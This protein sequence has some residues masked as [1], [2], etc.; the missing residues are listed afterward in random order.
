MM[1]QTTATTATVNYATTEQ[2]MAL[3]N[4]LKTM[5]YD[6]E[7]HVC[8]KNGIEVNGIRIKKEDSCI[9]PVIYPLPDDTVERILDIYN[10]NVTP[11]I[12]HIGRFFTE[13][14]L[15]SHI[16]T[17]ICKKGINKLARTLTDYGYDDLEE[18]LF[19]VVEDSKSEFGSIRV[20]SNIIENY[21]LDIDRLWDMARRNTNEATVITP[22]F[23]VMMS[24]GLSNIEMSEEEIDFL[25]NQNPMYVVTTH[26]KCKGASSIL[27]DKVKSFVE[28]SG[29]KWLWIPLSIHEVIMVPEGS[30]P[31]D[32]I[33]EM[34]QEVN[35]TQVSAYE[36]LSDHVYS[37]NSYHSER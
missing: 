20:D 33:T 26:S 4:E 36:Q 14:Y 11:E 18:Y 22:M 21:N 19:I 23:D 2:T 30:M 24:L 8:D 15:D 35:A 28:K 37:Y 1:N 6:A 25:R 17:G 3:V 34:V 32:G 12:D 31:E 7:L 10:K 9:A 27:S 13:E 16:M 5:G 29:K